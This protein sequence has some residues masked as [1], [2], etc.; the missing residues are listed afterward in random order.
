MK[1]VLFNGL[2][3]NGKH[4]GVRSSIELLVRA[5]STVNNNDISVEVIVGKDYN[6]PLTARNGLSLRPVEVSQGN[7]LKRIF[8][9]NLLLGKYYRRNNFDVFHSPGYILPFG[10]FSPAVVTIHDIIALQF[11]GL[12]QAE[13]SAYF[14]AMLPR[15]IKCAQRLIAIS[16]KVKEDILG[17]FPEVDPG[18]IAVVYQ[19]INESFKP[20]RDPATL[21]TVRARYRLPAQFILFVGNVEPKKNLL[22]M[23]RVLSELKKHCNIPHKLVIVGRKS[24]GYEALVAHI[25]SLGL[26][27]EVFLLGFVEEPDLPAIY[28]LADVFFFPSLYEGFGIPPLEAMACGTPVITSAAGALP[29]TTGGHCFFV[30]AENTAGMAKTLHDVVSDPALKTRYRERATEWSKK[31]SWRATAE[32]TLQAY[33]NLENKEMGRPAKQQGPPGTPTRGAGNMAAYA[34]HSSPAE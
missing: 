7:R 20:I 29:E 3:L 16:H 13:N 10:N 22:R 11:P 19:G 24:W 25:Q 17:R 6:G 32:Q 12:C 21:R 23:V 5:I 27:E 1:R 31:F 28:S 4:S 18:K 2:L 30:D 34:A 9:E 33:L 15:T 14:N 8:F 26:T